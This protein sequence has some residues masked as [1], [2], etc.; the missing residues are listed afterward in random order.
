MLLA[1]KALRDVISD[2]TRTYAIVNEAGAERT[3]LIAHPIN[4][5]WKLET[6]K[7][8]DETTASHYRFAMKVLRRW[9]RNAGAVGA[10]G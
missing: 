1:G 7:E 10:G 6:P 3:L 8:P 4:H 5:G 2:L 9:L